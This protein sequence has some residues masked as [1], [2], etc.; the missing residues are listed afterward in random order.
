MKRRS[1]LTGGAAAAASSAM[2]RLARSE[3]PDNP[4]RRSWD[5]LGGANRYVIQ[6]TGPAV[7]GDCYGR[8]NSAGD[9]N[10][11]MPTA[12]A[13]AELFE[14]A[15]MIL[16]GSERRPVS[17]RVSVWHQPN[18]MALR[19]VLSGAEVPL[20]A[21]VLF[22]I[23]ASTGLLRRNTVVHHRGIGPD[24]DITATLGFWYRT[25]E[26]IDDVRCLAGVWA[27]ETQIRHSDG[28]IPLVLESRTG[29]TG[30][31]FQPYLALSTKT[32]TY[33]CQIFWSGNWALQVE[34]D[35]DG[36]AVFGGI[37]NWQFRCRLGADG[38]NALRLPTVLFGRFDGD[39]NAA[40]QRLH[41]YRRKH[42]PNPERSIPVQFNSWY[43][44][45]GEPNAA[46]LLALV[47]VAKRLGCEVFV[48]DAGWFRTDEDDSAA[49][50]TARTGDW[51]TSRM[52]FPNGLREI[53]EACRDQEMRFGLWF[54]PEVIG[55][56]S[57]IRREHP[58][59]LHHVN[60]QLPPAA[61]RAV[62]NLGVPAA[63]QHAF[64]RV[65]RILSRVGVDWM[66]WDFNADLGAGGWAPGL[67]ESL[68][69]QD[70]LVAH[71]EGLYRL[72]DAIRRWFPDLILEMCASG[73]GRMDGE[74]LSHAHVN[75]VSDQ[76]G[77]L[78]KLA[79]HFGT[80]LAHP[81]V[82]CND[83]LIEWPP[84]SIAGYDDADAM[85]FDQRGD[86]PF[87][88]R[89]AMLGSFGI[90]ASIDRWPEEDLVIAAEHIT[91]YRHKLRSIIHHGDQ[92]LLTP[93]PPADGNGD[94]AAIWY[95]TKDRLNGVL[96]AFRLGS[97]GTSRI[98]PLA[99]L[100]SE[101]A[102][103]TSLFS[104]ESIADTTGEALTQGLGITIPGQF[105]SELVLVEAL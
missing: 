86:L 6:V 30:F 92:Y 94:W 1:F 40:T 28:A 67:P 57:A 9:D 49:A 76:P 22:K 70:P 19:M 74:L 42:R 20:E 83:W 53:S 80:Q 55:S 89:V 84:G 78:R 45:L 82:V 61:E 51:H 47:P 73:G 32:S 75:W 10:G 25:H 14:Q 104:A 3:S 12:A 17:W 15:A 31:A 77:P 44:Y 7:I 69:D 87:R 60:G 72:Q 4:A 105:Q 56:L 35:P 66:K 50:W 71:C 85:G 26:P 64:E 38:K 54:E 65:T 33:L 41:D 101:Q 16:E 63:R 43:P 58:E 48:V 95:V 102:Y 90:S 81:A 37:N 98:F 23:D 8:G 21:E 88:L 27:Q 39:L 79:I 52:R 24:I 96:F 2:G 68:T 99:G 100:L 13:K 103:R 34:P 11:E 18:P 5:L 91:L 46:A 93:A 97:T 29:K 36:A 62:L 59:W